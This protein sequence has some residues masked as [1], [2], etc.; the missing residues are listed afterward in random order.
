VTRASPERATRGG[1]T[2]RTRCAGLG[3]GAAESLHASGRHLVAA[4][5]EVEEH[6]RREAAQLSARIPSSVNPS[7]VA[8]T[9]HLTSSDATAGKRRTSL[10]TASSVVSSLSTSRSTSAPALPSTQR[11]A[12]EAFENPR[13]PSCYPTASSTSNS[14]S[15]SSSGISAHPPTVTVSH[16]RAALAQHRGNPVR[17]ERGSSP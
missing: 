12:A 4:A 10:P 15:S 14:F 5:A 7:A 3:W 16:H 9:T 1:A 8:L 17:G 6:E 2:L 11:A 13:P